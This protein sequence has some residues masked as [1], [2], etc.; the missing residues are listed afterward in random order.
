MALSIRRGLRRLEFNAPE[1]GTDS[2]THVLVEFACE[3]KLAQDQIVSINLGI[4]KGLERLLQGSPT[5]VK[6]AAPGKNAEYVYR[7][8]GH[9]DT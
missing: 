6:P 7:L 2:K 5:L 3:A 8:E 9:V 4:R 1:T